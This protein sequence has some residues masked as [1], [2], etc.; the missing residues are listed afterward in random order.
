M[1]EDARLRDKRNKVTGRGEER[2]IVTAR[3]RT[4]FAKT[5]AWHCPCNIFKN[6]KPRRNNA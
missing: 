3:F 2:I 6:K 5:K 1:K 4:G